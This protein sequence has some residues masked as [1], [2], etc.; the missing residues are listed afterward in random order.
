[1][2]TFRTTDLPLRQSRQE[3][4]LEGAAHIVSRSGL[5]PTE[6]ALI[7]SLPDLPKDLRQLVIAGNRTGAVAMLAGALHPGAQVIT[8]VY[9]Q[10]H[11]AAVQRNFSANRVSI[12]VVCAPWV[13]A[14]PHDAA[15]LQLSREGLP[16][17]LIL[18]LLQD[19][20]ENL[21]DGAICRIA[22][23]G[24]A[25]TIRRQVKSVFGNATVKS[26]SEGVVLIWARRT[27]PLIKRRDFRA[28]FEASL[29]GGTPFHLMSL[30]GVF[31]HRR[32]DAGGLALAEVAARF[33]KPAERIL[34]LGCGCGLVGIALARQAPGAHVTFVDSHARAT[35]CTEFNA[36]ACG[37]ADFRV[38]L[39]DTG[40]SAT[41]FTLAVGNPPYFSDFRIAEL[42]IRNAARAL[43]PGGRLCIVAKTARWHRDCM[44][45][46]FGNVETLPRRGYE[47]VT[48]LRQS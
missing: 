47:V 43:A 48:C 46:V 31:A 33:L 39:T 12:Q 30:P 15:L 27:G 18:D 8:H 25:D 28:G 32:P 42:F 19:L 16:N 45:A 24:D 3:T 11:A 10:H 40:T 21:V 26:G 35:Y 34:D 14:G 5:H 38:E 23:E 29:P 9:D 22:W 6:A 1:M 41:G 44:Q 36:S 37:L 2:L 7:R 20:H 13:P 17:E 4:F